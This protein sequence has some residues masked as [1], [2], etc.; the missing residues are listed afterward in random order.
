MAKS[1]EIPTNFDLRAFQSHPRSAILVS[2]ESS[3]A[4]F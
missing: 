4:T 3:R 2:I 1:G